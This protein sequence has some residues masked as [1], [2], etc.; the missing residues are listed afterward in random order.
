MP[1]GI[2][3][4]VPCHPSRIA[5]I[6]PLY[7]LH[8]YVRACQL[9]PLCSQRLVSP[10]ASSPVPSPSSPGIMARISRPI[11]HLLSVTPS[12]RHISHHILLHG[13]HGS[14][15]LSGKA[16]P[17]LADDH[18][19]LP[20]LPPPPHSRRVPPHPLHPRLHLRQGRKVPAQRQQ[21]PH[22]SSQPTKRQTISSHPRHIIYNVA[23]HKVQ[24]K[25]KCQ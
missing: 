8:L 2:H 11:L 5:S 10:H 21:A 4:S 1:H 23:N 6:A 16:S 17:L 13:L 3:H 14:L 25:Q 24:S 15:A 20:R 22:L 19:P 7:P 12:P 9:H 18:P